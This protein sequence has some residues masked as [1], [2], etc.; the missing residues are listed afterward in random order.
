MKQENKKQNMGNGECTHLHG[1]EQHFTDHRQAVNQA[2]K[3]S[4]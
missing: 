3:T 2:V 1:E 4:N